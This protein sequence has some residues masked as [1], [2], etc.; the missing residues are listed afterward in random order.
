MSTLHTAPLIRKLGRAPSIR[1]EEHTLPHHRP[2]IALVTAEPDPELPADQDMPLLLEAVHQAGAEAMAVCW[3]DAD[4]DWAAFDLAVI[5][6]ARDY[7]ARISEFLDWAD[8][9]AAL[10]RLAN[11]P[12]V[13]RWNADKR[14]LRDLAQLGIPVVDTHYVEPP[15]PDAATALPPSGEFVIKPA[16]GNGSR[17]AARY[18]AH[19]H[20]QA[21]HHLNQ[22]LAAGTTALIQP[23]VHRV[24]TTGEH[25]LAY[26]GGRLLH[27][28]QK[29]A[30]LTAG[31]SFTQPKVP[32]PGLTTC[33]PSPRETAVA[34]QALAAVPG[35]TTL[36]YA[37][38]DL[39]EGEDGRPLLME[40]ELIEPNLFLTLRR[41]SLPRLGAVLVRAARDASSHRT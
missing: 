11:D 12:A 37:R 32:H 15:N 38:V 26:A 34:E 24:D 1:P 17:L 21:L 2:R 4:A 5:R 25:S 40:L 22:L 7:P 31:S 28:T 29:D 18:D 16:I 8:R 35:S 3:D 23:Y 41:T 6:S 39:V 14:Y 9:C 13:L 27:A 30:V 19:D 33:T 36:L 10:T 20:E